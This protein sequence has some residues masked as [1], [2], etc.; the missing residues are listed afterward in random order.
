[1][2]RRKVYTLQKA[3]AN[4]WPAKVLDC[5]GTLTQVH[6][7]TGSD[8]AFLCMHTPSDYHG[9]YIYHEDEDDYCHFAVPATAYAS[10]TVL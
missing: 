2:S 8:Q 9:Y 5:I 7:H 4:Q 1:M 10:A 6:G 3:P